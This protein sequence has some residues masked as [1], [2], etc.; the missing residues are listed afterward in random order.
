MQKT[1]FLYY[2]KIKIIASAQLCNY[3]LKLLC[4]TIKQ[5]WARTQKMQLAYPV[6]CLY[7]LHTQLRIHLTTC[8]PKMTK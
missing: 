8:T 3:S 2:K 6:S 5:S 1:T 4:R 7:H